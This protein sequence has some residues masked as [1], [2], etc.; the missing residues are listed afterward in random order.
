MNKAKKFFV[1]AVVTVICMAMALAAL[2]MIA[3]AGFHNRFVGTIPANIIGTLSLVG[4]I[5]TAI[6]I[7]RV[8]KYCL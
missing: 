1:W 4:F 6:G 3:L 7:P 2:A 5:G 8:F